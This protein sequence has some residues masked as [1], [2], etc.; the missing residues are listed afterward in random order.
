MGD[1]SGGG[2]GVSGISTVSLT[3]EDPLD[4]QLF[5]VWISR[6]LGDKGADLYRSKGILSMAGHE[7]QFV[8]QC[9]H[10]IFDGERGPR[11]PLTGPRRSRLV[12]IG[13]NLDREALLQQ[14]LACRLRP[15]G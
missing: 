10:M 11:W 7:E 2:G 9:V 15:T 5:N 3:T 8:L 14:F 6:L 13:L 12:F 1:D 4:L